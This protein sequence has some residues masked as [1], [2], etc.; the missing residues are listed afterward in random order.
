MG[1]NGCIYVGRVDGYIYALNPDGS[2]RWKIKTN[3][4]IS[5]SPTLASDG[6]LYVGSWDGH[7]YAIQT[8]SG[9]LVNSPWPKFM[10]NRRNTGCFAGK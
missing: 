6:T 2:L 5:S 4:I 10:G 7:L 1:T 9:G 8:D 3:G